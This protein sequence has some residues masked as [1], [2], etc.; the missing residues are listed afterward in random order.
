LVF[1]WPF[2]HIFPLFGLLYQEKSGNP[3]LIRFVSGTIS[4]AVLILG[5]F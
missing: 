2:W 4:P 1:F 3:V 5:K